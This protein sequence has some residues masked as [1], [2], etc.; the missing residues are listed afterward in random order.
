MTHPT[1]GTKA[2]SSEQ[3][4][5]IHPRIKTTNKAM[6]DE[7]AYERKVAIGEILDPAIEAYFS[8]ESGVDRDIHWVMEILRHQQDI[9][10]SHEQL[11]SYIVVALEAIS[12]FVRLYLSVTPEPKEDK[13]QAE[14]RGSRR[15]K[16]FIEAVTNRIQEKQNLITDLPESVWK[17]FEH[18]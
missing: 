8:K 15:Y 16:S 18:E 11:N 9:L 14:R 7:E 2:S 12:M 10:Q 3:T 4:V 1:N 17:T 5:Q 6:L 13:E